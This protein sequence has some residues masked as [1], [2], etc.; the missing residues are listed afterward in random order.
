M[1]VSLFQF[2]VQ[3]V[4]INK[5]EVKRK[6]HEQNL[7][8]LD[9]LVSAVDLLLELLVRLPAAVGGDLGRHHLL[10]RVVGERVAVLRQ[11]AHLLKQE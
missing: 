3:C 2:Q 6:N 9:E 5:K 1:L 10:D 4:Q 8:A 7:E 11:Q